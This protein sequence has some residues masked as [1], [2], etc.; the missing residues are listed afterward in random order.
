MHV[1]VHRSL[2]WHKLSTVEAQTKPLL[3]TRYSTSNRPTYNLLPELVPLPL[4]PVRTAPP[5]ISIALPVIWALPALLKNSTKPAKSLGLPTLPVGCVAVRESAY[6]S[7]PKLVIREGKTPGQIALHMI[8]FG[9]SFEACILVRW[10]HAAFAGPSR[11]H[12]ICQ[13][14]SIVNGKKKGGGDWYN[15]QFVQT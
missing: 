8:F 1:D 5:S 11:S 7:N 2:A 3:R 13:Q 14:F 6:F 12:T 4:N 10:M 9:A 15:P